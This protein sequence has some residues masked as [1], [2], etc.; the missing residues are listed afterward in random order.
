MKFRKLA[1]ICLAA[2]MALS[3][4]VPAFAAAYA[5]DKGGDVTVTGTT[6]T[7]AIKVTV[8]TSAA[9]TVNPYGMTVN[10]ATTVA[11]DNNSA[12]TEKETA[13]IISP[14]YYALNYT[15]ANV[16]VKISALGVLPTPSSTS[17]GETN[18]AVFSE[19]PLAGQKGVTTKSIF[20]YLDTAI[21]SKSGEKIAWPGFTGKATDSQVVIAADT[22]SGA[23]PFPTIK[24]EY[25]LAAG[26]WDSSGSTGTL[27]KNGGVLAFKLDG[28]ANG[29]PTDAWDGDDVANVTITFTL[30]VTSDQSTYEANQAAAG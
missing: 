28:D 22:T 4:A 30:S 3:L 20:M 29:N 7:P 18:A 17:N 26:S 15:D 14:T 1:S 16:K 5:D 10:M 8:P 13:Q 19:K 23:G 11:G 6:K 25:V 9:V 2:V 12:L 27:A 24:N 21:A